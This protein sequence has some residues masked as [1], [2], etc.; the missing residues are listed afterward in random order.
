VSEA[1][2]PARRSYS[3]EAIA[4]IDNCNKQASGIARFSSNANRFSSL[5][6]FASKRKTLRSH[7]ERH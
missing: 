5:A 7:G 6:C 3:H 4:R 2:C 1:D